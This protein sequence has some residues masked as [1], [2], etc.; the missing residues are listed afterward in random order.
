MVYAGEHRLSPENKRD[1]HD[2]C[3]RWLSRI[4]IARPIKK[5]RPIR[6]VKSVIECSAVPRSKKSSNKPDTKVT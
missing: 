6:K 2:P 5:S 1:K 4:T 3:Y